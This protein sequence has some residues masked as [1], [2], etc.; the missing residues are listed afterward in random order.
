MWHVICLIIKYS[1][2]VT[3]RYAVAHGEWMFTKWI[4]SKK[5]THAGPKL[6]VS[7]STKDMHLLPFSI[8]M[9]QVSFRFKKVNSNFVQS[10]TIPIQFLPKQNN[11][12]WVLLESS[13]ETK[14]INLTG[15]GKLHYDGMMAIRKGWEI[16]LFC[17]FERKE[18][19][20]DVDRGMFVID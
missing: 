12:S 6:K 4:F 1:F 7:H 16:Y 9:E 19:D 18:F 8:L 17:F 15:H 13:M 3:F 14:L 5:S 10:L 2:F 20:V 11:P